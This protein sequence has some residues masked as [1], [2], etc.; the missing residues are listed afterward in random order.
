M[1]VFKK[2]GLVFIAVYKSKKITHVTEGIQK[3]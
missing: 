2:D 1:L 3:R